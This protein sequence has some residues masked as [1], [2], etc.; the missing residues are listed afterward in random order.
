MDNLEKYRKIYLQTK[1]PAKLQHEGW[2]NIRT[3]LAR[4]DL[5]TDQSNWLPRLALASLIL[6]FSLVGVAQAA[7]PDQILYPVKIVTDNLT[8]RITNQPQIPIEKRADEIIKYS[9]Q[10]E[11]PQLNQAVNQ[12]QKSLQQA[13]KDASSEGKNPQLKQTLEDQ[14]DR[15]EQ[16]AK[17]NPESSEKLQPLID[18]TEKLQGE[19][20]GART[21]NH[22]DDN[23]K[24][25]S[26]H[27]SSSDDHSHQDH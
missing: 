19:V 5:P 11:S 27:Q 18:Q 6:F 4:Q 14:K 7:N 20:Q 2:N 22:S 21:Q 17:S 23:D 25:S 15:F 24:S 12:Y 3:E 26:D 8:A 13:Q 16:A 1:V 9:Q 10:P